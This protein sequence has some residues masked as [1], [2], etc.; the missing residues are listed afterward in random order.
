MNPEVYEAIKT[1]CEL[2]REAYP[3]ETPEEVFFV[4]EYLE[5][6][7]DVFNKRK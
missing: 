6:I 4:E 7:D 3:H 2:V 5:L 1:L